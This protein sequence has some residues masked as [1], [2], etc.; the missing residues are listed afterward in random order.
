MIDQEGLEFVRDVLDD[1]LISG[2]VNGDRQLAAL[3]IVADALQEGD[4][5]A[6]VKEAILASGETNDGDSNEVQ[7]P[8]NGTD[9]DVPSAEQPVQEDG[10]DYGSDPA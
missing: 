10:P 7:S 5:V 9:A 1:T 8:S 4:G 2:Q 6:E 3:E